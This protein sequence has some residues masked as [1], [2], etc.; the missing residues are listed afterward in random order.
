MT[1]TLRSQRE[2]M[3]HIGALRFGLN[4]R[5]GQNREPHKWPTSN[6]TF[7]QQ[8]LKIMSSEYIDVHIHPRDA[9]Q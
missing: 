4:Q 5:L 2:I 8:C 9:R 7:K 6:Q 3:E 1:S